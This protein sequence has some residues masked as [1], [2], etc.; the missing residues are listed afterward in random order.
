MRASISIY[1]STHWLG[2]IRAN[3][4][5]GSMF[6]MDCISYC[7]DFGCAGAGG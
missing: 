4:D 1:G 5:A 3:L 6:N 2:G 7:V